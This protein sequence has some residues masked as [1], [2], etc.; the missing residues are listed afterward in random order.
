M[1]MV[2]VL[3]EEKPSGVMLGDHLMAFGQQPSGSTEEYERSQLLM[4]L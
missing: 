4:S 3:M 2:C 1:F